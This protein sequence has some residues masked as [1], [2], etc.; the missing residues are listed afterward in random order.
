MESVLRKLGVTGL[1]TSPGA[2]PDVLV[3]ATALDS[4]HRTRGIGRY[5]GNLVRAI[6][7][8]RPESPN[9][10]Y[11]RLGGPLQE[12]ARLG[13]ESADVPG[14]SEAAKPGR[15]STLQRPPGPHLSRWILNEWRL[16]E[17]LDGRCEIYHGTEPAAIPVSDSFKTVVTCHDVI[18]LMFP[19]VYL[20]FPYVFW[21]LYYRRLRQTGRWGD[22]DHVIAISEATKRELLR[23]FDI[24][25]ERISVVHNGIDHEQFQPVEDE[26]SIRG[27]CAEWEL[28]KPFILYLGGYD[29]RK[30]VDVLIRAL[31]HVPDEVDLVLA[32]GVYS[33]DRRRM[34]ELADSLG[35]GDR[36][37]FPGYVDDEVLCELYAAAEVFAYPS[38]AE[39]FGLQLLEAMAVGCPVVASNRSSLPEVVGDAG[40]LVDPEDPKMIGEALRRCVDDEETRRRLEVDGRERAKEFSWRRTAEETIA[41]YRKVLRSS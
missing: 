18:P 31:P 29:Y 1:T 4:D 22:I 25:P 38:L 5:V 13:R 39:G 19:D 36:I 8:I 14:A 40:L 30:N 32:G 9:V 11:L 3:D 41:V 28:E 2:E 20:R 21:R 17:E 16:A 24:E 33:G 34:E 10:G 26:R 15:S 6:E 37:R 35:V 7:D 27:F 12:L 23:H